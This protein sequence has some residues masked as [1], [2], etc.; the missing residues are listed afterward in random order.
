MVKNARPE[1]AIKGD[2]VKAKIAIS[3]EPVYPEIVG[4]FIIL[5]PLVEV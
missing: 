2:I 5:Y 4:M 1:I 3:I